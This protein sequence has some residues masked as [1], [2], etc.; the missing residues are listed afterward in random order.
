MPHA[1]GRRRPRHYLFADI[2]HRQFDMRTDRTQLGRFAPDLATD[3]QGAARYG[4]DRRVQ[5]RQ[6]TALY[7]YRAEQGGY[8]RHADGRLA[9]KYRSAL[10]V[11]L[12]AIAG[13][14]TTCR[15]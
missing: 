8:G 13:V 12:S 10:A 15:G 11:S 1:P 5:F 6:P 14:L 7:G 2:P 4:T 3:L 9:R